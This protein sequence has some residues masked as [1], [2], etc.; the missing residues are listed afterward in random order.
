MDELIKGMQGYIE[1]PKYI[2]SELVKAIDTDVDELISAPK[3]DAPLV[4][5]KPVYDDLYN[6][7]TASVDTLANEVSAHSITTA[8]VENL[9][10]EVSTLEQTTDSAQL[11]QSTAENETQVSNDRF[12]STLLDFQ[13][14]LQKGTK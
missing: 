10:I 2:Q 11:L 14:A 13:T 9:R 1:K 4:V 7:Y 3:K 6:D 8:Q 12:T 5:P